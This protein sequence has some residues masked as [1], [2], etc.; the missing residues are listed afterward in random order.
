MPRRW[1]SGSTPMISIT[2]MRSLKAL[3]ATVTNPTGRPPR[4][5]RRRPARRS[6]NSSPSSASAPL[7]S[8]LQAKK[9]GS[10]KTSRN[11]AKTGSHARS[12]NSTTASRSRSWNSRISTT[13]P[14]GATRRYR[15]AKVTGQ[16]SITT[17]RKTVPMSSLFSGGNAVTKRDAHRDRIDRQSSRRRAG[18]RGTRV[19]GELALLAVCR[20]AP[21]FLH[22]TRLLALPA[23][24]A[25]RD[26]PW[27]RPGARARGR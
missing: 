25:S 1:K 10:P 11:E 4:P 14:T 7:P 24:R 18:C 13:P 2:P 27:P 6:C 8:A 26:R 15:A 21:A 3:R 16:D 5:R 17:R 20:R 23:R 9:I 22:H 19:R 12:E